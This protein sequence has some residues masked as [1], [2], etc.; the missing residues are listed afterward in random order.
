MA[1]YQLIVEVHC[2]LPDWLL[3][4]ATAE[5]TFPDSTCGSTPMYRLYINDEMLIDRS[6]IWGNNKFI[7][8]NL[9]VEMPELTSDNRL[10]IVAVRSRTAPTVRFSL[11]NF[12]WRKSYEWETFQFGNLRGFEILDATSINFGT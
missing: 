12:T 5:T 1:V 10:I 8:E 7:R 6:W 3:D 11:K 4:P 9:V 2:Q